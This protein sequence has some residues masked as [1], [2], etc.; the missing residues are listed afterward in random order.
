[1]TNHPEPQ[2]HLLKF[3]EGSGMK[4]MKIISLHQ[5]GMRTAEF[6]TDVFVS[7]DGTLAVASCYLSKLRLVVLNN[8]LYVRDFDVTLPEQNVLALAL[9]QPDLGS[10][11]TLGIAYL[12]GNLNV[13][14]MVR[15]IHVEDLELSPSPS[16][17]FSPTTISSEIFSMSD[18]DAGV[19]PILFHVSGLGDEESSGLLLLGGREIQ[20]YSFAS[21]ESQRK[22]ASKQMRT[23]KRKQ[24]D[25]KQEVRKAKAKEQERLSRKRKPTKALDWPWSSIASVCPMED[26][27]VSKFLLGD[28]FGYLSLLSLDLWDERGMVI[29]PLGQASRTTVQ[30]LLLVADYLLH[31]SHLPLLRLH[32]FLPRTFT[33]GRILVHRICFG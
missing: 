28:R 4:V 8:G 5:Q 9:C 11:P 20:F 31:S 22:A 15:N 16:P 32:H 24:S 3:N 18:F 2:L 23:E 29:V 13:A 19:L 30:L 6:L 25:S 33:W 14:L 26:D 12:N 1:M 7:E 10:D 21:K 27:D 17:I